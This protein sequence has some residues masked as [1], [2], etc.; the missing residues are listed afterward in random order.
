MF[1]RKYTEECSDVQSKSVIRLGNLLAGF[2]TFPTI[3]GPRGTIPAPMKRNQ[4]FC[5]AGN[6]NKP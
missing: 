2:G 1:L 3:P 5:Y 4:V 6:N